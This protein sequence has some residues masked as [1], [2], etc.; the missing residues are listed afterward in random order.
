MMNGDDQVRGLSKQALEFE[1]AQAQSYQSS[2]RNRIA[3]EE[4]KSARQR[5]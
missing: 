4:L 5:R 2:I 3:N 1:R